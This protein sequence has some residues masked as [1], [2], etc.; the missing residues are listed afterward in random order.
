MAV[1][2]RSSKV[3]MR[4]LSSRNRAAALYT[5]CWLKKDTKY[6]QNKRMYVAEQ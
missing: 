3:K 5:Q 4:N 1:S 6:K 2:Y